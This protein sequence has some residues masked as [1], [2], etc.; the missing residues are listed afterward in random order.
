M[1]ERLNILFVDSRNV[2]RSILAESLANKLVKTSGFKGILNFD[3]C[4]I[5][6]INGYRVHPDLKR[7]AQELNFELSRN[8]ARNFFDV[9]LE[10]FDLIFVFEHWHK[11]KV[12][13]VYLEEGAQPD[14]VFYVGSFVSLENV[15]WPSK[16]GIAAKLSWLK[17]I[18][19]P[20]HEILTPL[21]DFYEE[22]LKTAKIIQQAV[23]NLLYFFA[24]R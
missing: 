24:R 4:G 7:L 9:A 17:I 23:R 8:Y 19:L 13:S 6:A 14:M 12:E 11:S 3:S 20:S 18:D 21:S 22:K 2:F 15:L 1:I 10:S 16:T 5:S